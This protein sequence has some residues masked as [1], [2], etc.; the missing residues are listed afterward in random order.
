MLFPIMEREVKK[1]LNA[2]IIVSLIYV[3]WGANLVPVRKKN[4]E[5][6]LCVDFRNLNKISKKD[7]YPL[8][9]MEHLLQRVTCASRMSMIDGFSSYNHIFVL[10]EDREKMTF[11]TPWD[12]FM[13]AKIPFVLMNTRATFQPAMDITFTRE[14]DKFVVI[15]LYGITVFSRYDKNHCY[16]LRKVF[17]KCIF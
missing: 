3:E 11:T 13:Y 8:P 17:L 16:H 6:R 7:N 1:P 2:Q 15:Y 10:R 14:K 9:N 5:A 12:T 4:E